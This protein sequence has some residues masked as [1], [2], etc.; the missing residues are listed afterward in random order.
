MNIEITG[1]ILELIGVG[2]LLILFMG[3]NFGW[4]RSNSRL[5]VHFVIACAFF[6]LGVKYYG[7]NLSSFGNENGAGFLFG[8]I[9]FV[10]LYASLRAFY[11]K[12]FSFEPDM[13]AYSGYSTRDQRRLNFLD[14]VVFLVPTVLSILISLLLAN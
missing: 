10:V 13:V 5:A 2:Y 12:I 7:L 4:L 1:D 9:I 3:G 6:V 8:P 14:Y 11:K